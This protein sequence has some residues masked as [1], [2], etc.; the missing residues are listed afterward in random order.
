MP[1]QIEYE[2]IDEFGIDPL[3]SDFHDSVL[4]VS[5]FVWHV[6]TSAEHLNPALAALNMMRSK[7]W[8]SALLIYNGMNDLWDFTQGTR[9]KVPDTNELN[10][11]LLKTKSKKRVGFTTI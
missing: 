8:W 11:L 6:V 1:K 3:R 4:A 10:N 2:T 7:D 5:S 9:I